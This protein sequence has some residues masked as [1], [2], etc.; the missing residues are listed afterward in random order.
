MNILEPVTIGFD[1]IRT[2]K[3][4]A[5]LSILGILISVG[6]VTGIVSMGDGLRSTVMKQF[7]QMGGPSLIWVDSP[8]QWYRKG[9]KML[10]R[11]WEEYLTNQDVD[12]IRDASPNIRFAVPVIRTN[13]PVQYHR[14]SSSARIVA[15]TEHYQQIENF[16]IEQ[17]RFIQSDDVANAAKVAVIGLE[18][19]GDLYGKDNAIGK[20]L[21]IEGIRYQVVG[22]VNVNR[23]FSTSNERYMVVPITTYQKRIYGNNRVNQI[24]VM[25]DSPEHASE[26]ALKIRYVIKNTHEHADDF[27]IR[28][29]ENE[30]SQFNRVVSIMKLVAG[31]IAGISL[32]VGGIGI[33]NIMLV[34]VTERTRE[35]GIRMAVGAKRRSILMQFILEAMVLCLFGGFLGIVLGIG[36]GAGISAYVKA[37]TKMPFESVVTPGLMTFAILYSAAIGLFFGVYPAWRAS[38]MDPVEALRHE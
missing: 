19:A 29:G 34:S 20:E 13:N 14:V 36:I 21:R 11:E 18:L 17:G 38:K 26:V 2:H 30:I 24:T 1:Q 8:N 15:T 37:A 28:T 10:R 9:N 27:Q 32:I 33:M 23:V 35:I 22:V 16:S 7:E 31:G 6:S 12:T 25:A 3:L 5:T 4:R